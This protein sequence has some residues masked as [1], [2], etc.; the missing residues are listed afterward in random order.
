M[1]LPKDKLSFVI[2]C[3]KSESTIEKIIERIKKTV[4]DRNP[5]EIICV[6]DG[7]PDN[8]YEVLRNIALEDDK[9]K[10]INLARNFGQ[11]NALMA[12]FNHVGGNVI[13]ALDDDGQ[14][15]PE[16]C[17]K[18]INALNEDTDLVYADYPVKKESPFRLFGSW[19]SNKVSKKLCSIPKG[20]KTNSYF[21]CKRF[22]IE[23]IIR[24]D[25]PYTSLGGLFF[26]ATQNV[27]NVKVNHHERI[28]G[29]SGYS[30]HTLISLFLN[31]FTN[32]SVKPLRLASICG[33]IC[34]IIGFVYGIYTIVHKIVSPYVPVGYSSLMAVILFIGGM[35]MLM[36][37]MIGE[38]LGR[39]YINSNEAPQF[40]IKETINI[41]M[42]N[43]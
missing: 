31:G 14:N 12:G 41:G 8:V 16:E 22:L 6:V 28:S 3:Y 20:I 35:I 43:K 42:E 26:R 17:Y 11:H 15:P 38:Y 29:K 40:V 36:L 4:Q 33:C 13:I 21:A 30:L 39:L 19:F 27:K 24:Y 5:F 34:A 9:I 2:P 37:G 1:I 10:V 32:F 23:E 18:L 7:S 25:H